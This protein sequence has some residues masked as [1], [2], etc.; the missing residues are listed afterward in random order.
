MAFSQVLHKAHIVGNR[1]AGSRRRES[2]IARQ[3]WLVGVA[4][5][6]GAIYSRS[7]RESIRRSPRQ[8]SRLDLS[9]RAHAI[10]DYYCQPRGSR[11]RAVLSEDPERRTV[12]TKVLDAVAKEA[13]TP[14]SSPQAFLCC[15]E[16]NAST[17]RMRFG[18]LSTVMP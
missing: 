3:L 8:A 4:S 14:R 15:F 1:T 18:S 13:L 7:W 2:R 12:R 9:S 6:A 5:Q 16:R 10:W 17:V 11:S